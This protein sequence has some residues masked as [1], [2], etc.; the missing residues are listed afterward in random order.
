M[1]LPKTAVTSVDDEATV[2]LF[3]FKVVKVPLLP[4]LDVI[5]TDAGSASA[6]VAL[7]ELREG[8]VVPPRTIE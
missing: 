2:I 4:M 5:V 8:C 7:P 3:G 1:P 6:A